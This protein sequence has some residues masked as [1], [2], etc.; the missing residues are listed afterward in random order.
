[1]LPIDLREALTLKGPKSLKPSRCAD[2]D[3]DLRIPTSISSYDAVTAFIV[4]HA[5]EVFKHYLSAQE[6]EYIR[7]DSV[8]GEYIL[9]WDMM[10]VT[11]WIGYRVT[12]K[13]QQVCDL[14][15]TVHQLQ[16]LR[17]ELENLIQ[18]RRARVSNA[19][20][21]STANRDSVAA[22]DIWVTLWQQ[23]LEVRSQ[24]LGLQSTIRQSAC[25]EACAHD[26]VAPTNNGDASTESGGASWLRSIIDH[27]VQYTQ[28]ERCSGASVTCIAESSSLANSAM[29]QVSVGT[30][31]NRLYIAHSHG[32]ITADTWSEIIGQLTTRFGDDRC[33][34][35]SSMQD[36]LLCHPDV[37]PEQY[38]HIFILPSKCKM[39]STSQLHGVVYTILR[40]SAY[41]SSFI[42]AG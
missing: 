24:L 12:M 23:I 26:K 25:L 31:I 32:Y 41:V 16:R 36:Y 3:R 8:P 19:A 39:G 28:A 15:E 22:V 6:R 40:H 14:I 13:T 18:L 1:M 7:A 2:C 27:Y 17:Q 29:Q 9:L 10:H 11:Q 34:M 21:P 33:L 35:I 37:V 30:F 5:Q 20:T 42:F 4:R 38:R